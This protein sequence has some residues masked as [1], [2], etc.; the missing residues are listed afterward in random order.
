MRHSNFSV[1]YRASLSFFAHLE[2]A[3]SATSSRS[4]R[5]GRAGSIKPGDIV[6]VLLE[7]VTK[8]QEQ[9]LMDGFFCDT[10]EGEVDVGRDFLEG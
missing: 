4:V 3:L 2:S 6:D 7:D 1:A 10:S 8:D 5:G 9:K